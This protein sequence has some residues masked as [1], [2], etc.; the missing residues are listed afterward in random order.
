MTNNEYPHDICQKEGC[1]DASEEEVEA[2]DVRVNATRVGVASLYS[3]ERAPL[4]HRSL[5][6][7]VEDFLVVGLV[8]GAT[9]GCGLV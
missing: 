2:I 5:R 9:R 6:C 8:E 3:D 4:G 7:W 1:V